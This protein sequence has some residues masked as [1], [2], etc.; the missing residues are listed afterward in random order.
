[1]GV[2]SWKSALMLSPGMHMLTSSGRETVPVT[3][4]VLH[5]FA[6]AV[7]ALVET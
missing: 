7:N 2:M 5:G 4:A 1:M 6:N 3:S